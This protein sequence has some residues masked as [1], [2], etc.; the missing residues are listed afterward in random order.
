MIGR[1]VSLV[2]RAPAKAMTTL[3]NAPAE[4][5]AAL[6]ALRF[7]ADWPDG[8]ISRFAGLA[9]QVVYP[10]GAVIFREG[11]QSEQVHFVLSGRVGLE[12]LVPARGSVRLLTLSSG[13]LLGWSPLVRNR[14][15]TAAAIA[16]EESRLLSMSGAALLAWCEEDPAVGFAV[17]RRLA[18]S[19]SERL[20]AT[21]LQL[22]D[23][24]SHSAP[25]VVEASVKGAPRG[26]G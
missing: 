18:L 21:R 24:F 1:P 3:P 7:S 26:P 17:M 15:M 23:L 8:M 13:D 4:N 20:T 19:L 10:A 5:E 11:E 22:L 16:L 14:A 2:R 9:T 12:M 25:A 6:R